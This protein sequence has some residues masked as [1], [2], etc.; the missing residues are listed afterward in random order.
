ML[1]G[2]FPSGRPVPLLIPEPLW[3]EWNINGVDPGALAELRTEYSAVVGY[4]FEWGQIIEDLCD[5]RA[6]TDPEVRDD[7]AGLAVRWSFVLSEVHSAFLNAGGNLG[8]LSDLVMLFLAKIDD[9]RNELPERV[10]R[11]ALPDYIVFDEGNDISAFAV[12]VVGASNI[13]TARAWMASYFIPAVLPL[14]IDQLRAGNALARTARVAG[15][16]TQ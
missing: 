3:R 16:V 1:T 9:S 2:D 10:R 6:V 13:P 12:C 14:F 15:V 8:E 7:S 5:T 4:E 11:D